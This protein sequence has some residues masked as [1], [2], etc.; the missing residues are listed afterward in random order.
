MGVI[1][2]KFTRMPAMLF[3]LVQNRMRRMKKVLVQQCSVLVVQQLKERLHQKRER[4]RRKVK[5]L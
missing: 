5:R 2:A 1:L 4:Y 3:Y